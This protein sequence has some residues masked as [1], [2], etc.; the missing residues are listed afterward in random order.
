MIK[1]MMTTK[2]TELI[3]LCV[4]LAP[5][6]WKLN[7]NDRELLHGL[8]VGVI[9]NMFVRTLPS[10][11]QQYLDVAYGY[12]ELPVSRPVYHN[13]LKWNVYIYTGDIHEHNSGRSKPHR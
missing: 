4:E 3:L 10:D 9:P 11:I 13:H 12:R 6:R 5:L 1:T 8:R 2:L 7:A